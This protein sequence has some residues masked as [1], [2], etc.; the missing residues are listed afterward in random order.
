VSLRVGVGVVVA[1]LLGM[2]TTASAAA[3]ATAVAPGYVSV[4]GDP[5][6]ITAVKVVGPRAI[7]LTL[8]TP[9]FTGP[10]HV[11]VDLPTGYSAQPHRR[12][13][14]TYVLAGIM[15]TY[16]SFND[17]VD[18]LALTQ[19]YP[20]IIVS[21]NGDSGWWSDWYNAGA[22]GPPMYETFVIDQLI[23]LI[24]ANYRTIANRAH[25]AIAG[26][27]MGG[28]GAM[29]L[30]ADH[31]DLFGYAA[32]LSGAV[33]TNLPTIGAVLTA[34][35]TFQNAP[36]DA[37]YGPRAT[38][39]IR[40]RGHNPTDLA[41]NL[42]GMDL[43]VRS[44]DGAPDPQIGESG[45]ADTVSCL[46]EAGVYMGSVD[47]NAEL[48]TLGI[49]HLWHDYGA[50]CHTPENFERELK[51]TFQV[52]T[53]ELADPPAAPNPFSYESI[54]PRFTIYGW[55]IVA[56]PKRALEFM[57]LQN[58]GSR[59]LTLIGSG[60]TTVTTPPLFRGMRTVTLTNATPTVAIPTRAGRITFTVDLG[61]ADTAQEYTT[62]ATT[63]ETTRTVT[64]TPHR[65]RKRRR[66]RHRR[67][68]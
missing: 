61:P 46:I 40:W 15:N 58:A 63:T 41:G 42:R 62:G 45:P 4:T 18:G 37:I 48:N 30:A 17:V 25:R 53:S 29:M 44:A 32:S 54:E 57:H 12:W 13:P 23:P 55:Q 39:E 7:T 3:G 11:D 38:Q 14:V 21:P 28:Y 31:P 36:L 24:D 2:S 8:S 49:P 35:P 1:A 66:R 59:G 47:L 60:T 5:A 56:D 16:S 19:S 65:A 64:F 6:Q 50:G 9:A 33:D 10:T 22:F 67:A 51:D 43:Q 27:S 68:A 52:F 34:S 26:I 20:S